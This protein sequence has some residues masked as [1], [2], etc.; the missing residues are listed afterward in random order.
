MSWIKAL[1]KKIKS[2]PSFVGAL[3]YFL[4]GKKPVIF[5][6]RTRA[7]NCQHLKSLHWL[8]IGPE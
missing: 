6:G 2:V 7:T 5:Q 3:F 8:L 1:I 4:D